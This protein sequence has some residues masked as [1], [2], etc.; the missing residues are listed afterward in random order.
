MK[1]IFFREINRIRRVRFH[2]F[3]LIEL[4]VVIAI[5]GILASMLLPALSRARGTAKGIQCVNN[6][7]QITTATIF[8]TND[9]DG[10]IP[11]G[12]VG[13][14]SGVSITYAYGYYVGYHIPPQT[15]MCPMDSKGKW[16]DGST[17][18]QNICYG[19][20][21]RTFGAT[22]TNTNARPVKI[23]DIAKRAKGGSLIM[24]ADSVPETEDP[25]K[26]AYLEG[27][28]LAVDYVPNNS[29][30]FWYPGTTVA[31]Y[32]PFG[33]R[34]YKRLNYSSFDGSV[35]SVSPSEMRGNYKE[36][37]RPYQKTAS[38]NLEWKYD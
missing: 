26:V 16:N 7:K 6:L 30:V 25:T 18:Q 17:Y 4:L 36:Y 21:Q 11:P 33:V 23:T 14:A 34:H 20:N 38:T 9:Y 27:E 32:Y 1:K 3:T 15:F 29:S 8:Y 19:L 2:V 12:T 31:A 5:I 28:Y 13:S 24:Y 10:W 22:W 37:C 35:D